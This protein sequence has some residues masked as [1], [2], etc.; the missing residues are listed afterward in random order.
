MNGHRLEEAPVYIVREDGTFYPVEERER[1]GIIDARVLYLSDAE[2]PLA[3]WI[4]WTPTGIL[5]FYATDETVEAGHTR[6]L[7]DLVGAVQ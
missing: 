5:V 3:R 7:L 1:N 2:D 4:V 6:H